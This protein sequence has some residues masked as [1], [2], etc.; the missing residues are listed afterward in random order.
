MTD[1]IYCNE[2]IHCPVK[3]ESDGSVMP[4]E[5]L[6]GYNDYTC[7]F[8]NQDDW[9][10]NRMPP[11]G[12]FCKSGEKQKT[13]VILKNMDMPDCCVDCP[14]FDEN[15]ICLATGF[16]YADTKLGRRMVECPLQR[17]SQIDNLTYKEISN[18]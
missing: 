1:I 8:I 6:D 5:T 4:P 13:F 16:H 15:D 11:N 12:F 17:V 2:C 3:D 18:D 9:F 7:P 14:L 10:Y